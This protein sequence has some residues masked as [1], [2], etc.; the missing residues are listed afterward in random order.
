MKQTYGSDSESEPEELPD[1]VDV[2]NE[3]AKKCAKRKSEDQSKFKGQTSGQ[4]NLLHQV[5]KD[6]SCATP[7]ES[8]GPSK[9]LKQTPKSVLSAT[10][11]ATSGRPE[12]VESAFTDVPC[13]ANTVPQ[14]TKS[15]GQTSTDVPCTAITATSGR[16][17]TVKSASTDVPCTANTVLQH[18]KS[19]RQTS[20][21]V[22]CTITIAAL[23]HPQSTSESVSCPAN[24]DT[25]GL[26][27]SSDDDPKKDSTD[28]SGP[29]QLQK[30]EDTVTSP[31]V[32]VKNLKLSP[33]K[34]FSV[35]FNAAAVLHIKNVIKCLEVPEAIKNHEQQTDAVKSKQTEKR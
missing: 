22:P 5:S 30:Q 24:S 16:L 14:H 35:P 23:G 11:T 20:R 33:K 25:S 31:K 8:P 7:T 10:I 13:T 29:L 34:A 4:P 3:R 1:L 12:T 27:K 28:K 32:I 21:D 2:A 9:S 19:P 15:P 18:M 6:D 26:P 17:E